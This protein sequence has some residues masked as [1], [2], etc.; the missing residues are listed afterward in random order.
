MVD[1]RY[2][3]HQLKRRDRMEADRRRRREVKRA[4]D[5]KEKR[6]DLE[7]AAKDSATA[8]AAAVAFSPPAP[9][10]RLVE[11]EAELTEF[12]IAVVKALMK[13]EEAIAEVTQR[14]DALLAQAFVMPDGRRVFRTEDGTRVFD[15]FGEEVSADEIDPAAI[16][17]RAPTWEEF[18]ALQVERAELVDERDRLHDFQTKL[19]EARV[20]ISDGEISDA[21][22]DALEAELADIMPDAVRDEVPGIASTTPAP[23]LTPA[24]S[25]SVAPSTDAPRTEAPTLHIDN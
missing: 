6:D 11:F 22:L 23:N 17:T 21:E 1:V 10:E 19:D 3:D 14:I 13:N 2:A 24:F 4:R 5:E 8:F 16:D 9:P 18:Q 15:E 7:D 25:G 20:E 12:D